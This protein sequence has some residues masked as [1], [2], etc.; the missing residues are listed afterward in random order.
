MP[1][2]GMAL[3]EERG[4]S[5]GECGFSRGRRRF[6]LL[7]CAQPPA[8]C[9]Q[10]GGAL[11]RRWHTQGD[12]GQT[13]SLSGVSAAWRPCARRRLYFSFIFFF[14][15]LRD[16]PRASLS[17]LLYF[18]FPNTN[19]PPRPTTKTHPPCTSNAEIGVCVTSLCTLPAGRGAGRVAGAWGGRVREGRGEKGSGGHR[20]A[21]LALPFA[22]RRPPPRWP[23]GRGF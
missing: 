3:F 10:P 11:C 14:V 7:G 12:G 22:F 13:L 17:S 6:C 15:R 21:A 1:P 20:P 18:R 9:P 8:V 16:K 19:P 4:S 2:S 23:R 5:S